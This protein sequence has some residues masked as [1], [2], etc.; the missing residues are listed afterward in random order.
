MSGKPREGCEETDGILGLQHSRDQMQGTRR[1]FLTVGHC[2]RDDRPGAGIVPAIE[3]EFGPRRTEFEKRPLA[4]GLHPARPVDP[5]QPAFHRLDRNRQASGPERCHSHGRI[6]DLVRTREPGARQVEKTLFIL[7]DH[8]SAFFPGGEILT[9]NGEGR[10]EVAGTG[11]DDV[12]RRRLLRRNDGRAP[13]L[14]MPAF[15]KAMPSR[16]SP[17]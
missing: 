12:K 4:E 16:A 17:R 1:A 2:R 8:A 6:D 9:K 11:A 13:R 7:E 10:A 3:P 5:L 15:S 14:R